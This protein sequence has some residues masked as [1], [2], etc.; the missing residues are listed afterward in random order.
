MGSQRAVHDST[1]SVAG[2]IHVMTGY[3]EGIFK[4]TEN[5]GIFFISGKG[6]KYVVSE[7]RKILL[8][9]LNVN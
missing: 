7:I 1:R 4:A 3:L 8:R 6:I 2:V 5:T 9:Q